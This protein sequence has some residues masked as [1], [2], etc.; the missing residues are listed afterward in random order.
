MVLPQ[1]VSDYIDYP[2][3]YKDKDVVYLN[4]RTE[5]MVDIGRSGLQIEER[6]FEETFYNNFKAGAFSEVNIQSSYFTKMKDVEASTLLP[7]DTKFKEIKVKKFKTKEVFDE[8][9]FYQDLFSTS[10]IYPSLRQGAIT[11]LKYT[12]DFKDPHFF[13]YVVLKKYYPVENFEFAIN[14]DKDVVFDIKYFFTDTIN[15]DFTKQEK[16]KRVIYTWKA[17]NLKSYKNE[18]NAPDY[19]CYLPQ[20]VPYIKS[21][22]VN[23]KEVPILR[24]IDD[25]FNWYNENISNLDHRHTDDMI[26]TVGSI[27]KECRNDSEKVVVIYKWVQNNIKY[28]ANEYG[29]GGFIPRHPYQI[30]EKRYGDCKDMATIIIELLDIA[31][32]KAYFTWIGTRDLPYS[33]EQIPTSLVDNHMIATYILNNRHYFLDATNSHNPMDL[34]SDFIQGKEGLIKKDAHRYEIIMVPEVPADT[35][36]YSDTAYVNIDQGKVREK[37]ALSFLVIII[38]A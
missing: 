25:L 35:N 22:K 26:S 11:R 32:V 8:D 6:K 31:D 15:I 10:F 1:K 7:D 19:L 9:I 37:E 2:V 27:V 16:G 38:Q 13:P 12:L 20:I 28:V 21:Y 5:V 24:N 4:I 36:L 14:S 30:F 33:Y 18:K 34:P 17:K 23:N 29:L 3:R